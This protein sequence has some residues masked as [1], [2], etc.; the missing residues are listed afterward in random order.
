MS[1]KEFSFDE[2]AAG[3][4]AVGNSAVVQLP[5]QRVRNGLRLK[6]GPSNSATVYVG[7]NPNVSSSSG[8]PLAAGET[9]DVAVD[10]ASKVY[11]IASASNQ[12]LK[13][14]GA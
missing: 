5:A 14:L 12:T 10:D 13:F 4:V 2:F 8:Y 11:V 7:N 6:A 9:L 3:S 1:L